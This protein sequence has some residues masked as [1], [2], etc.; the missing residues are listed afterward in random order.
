MSGLSVKSF[1]NKSTPYIPFHLRKKNHSDIEC[2][3]ADCDI[4]DAEEKTRINLMRF[5]IL[6]HRFKNMMKWVHQMKKKVKMIK[7]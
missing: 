1:Y 5:R 6:S 2:K 3:I 7:L 4:S